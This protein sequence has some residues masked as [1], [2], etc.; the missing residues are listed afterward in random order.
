M[1]QDC[2]KGQW[3][4]VDI[5]NDIP[6]LGYSPIYYS[7]LYQMPWILEGKEYFYLIC[8]RC[9]I[10]D[11]TPGPVQVSSVGP[12]QAPRPYLP[13]GHCFRTAQY[14]SNHS[15]TFGVILAVHR[16]PEVNTDCHALF[17]NSFLKPSFTSSAFYP[18]FLLILFSLAANFHP[19]VNKRGCGHGKIINIHT[20][21]PFTCLHMVEWLLSCSQKREA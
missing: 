11:S 21:F 5:L 19:I 18:F 14:L 17:Y 2:Q 7:L 9:E 1:D 13:A 3:N 10:P 20:L 8:V 16:Y 4:R 12:V 15:S 6:P